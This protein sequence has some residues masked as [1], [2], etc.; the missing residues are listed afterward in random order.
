MN[1]SSKEKWLKV[2]EFVVVGIATWL[3]PNS[4][5]LLFL[6]KLCFQVLAA[7]PP[8]KPGSQDKSKLLVEQ[9]Q[10]NQI[11]SSTTDF[12]QMDESIG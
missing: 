10:D 2:I 12:T 7:L 4:G 5:F 1:R 9:A 3:N 6:L 8:G 11:V